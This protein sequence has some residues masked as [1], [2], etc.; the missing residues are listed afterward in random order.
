MVIH[1]PPPGTYTNTAGD[2]INGSP[3]YKKDDTS[4]FAVSTVEEGFVA[5]WVGSL[6]QWNNP[7]DTLGAV[8][9]GSAKCPHQLSGDWEVFLQSGGTVSD[10]SFTVSCDVSKYNSPVSCLC[11]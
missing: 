8:F 9:G 6:F 7:G 11:L 2:D 4:W 5:T 10:P 1:H 3:I